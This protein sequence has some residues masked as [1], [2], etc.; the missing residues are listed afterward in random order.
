MKH[1][2]MLLGK[3]IGKTTVFKVYHNRGDEANNEF[4]VV[5]NVTSD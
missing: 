1:I 5:N 4:Q 2:S 3:N